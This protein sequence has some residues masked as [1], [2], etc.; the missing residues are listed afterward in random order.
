MNKVGMELFIGV[1]ISAHHQLDK[2]PKRIAPLKRLGLQLR[3]LNIRSGNLSMD[4]GLKPLALVFVISLVAACT[5]TTDVINAGNGTLSVSA[6]AAP[7]VV[8][9]RAA[10]LAIERRALTV[11]SRENFGQARAE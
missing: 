2:L 8:A 7:A 1:S 3:L 5:S 4:P 10:N 9:F 6:K 11:R